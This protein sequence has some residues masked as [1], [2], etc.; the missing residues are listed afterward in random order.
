MS[1][2]YASRK[3]HLEKAT[4]GIQYLHRDPKKIE[5]HNYATTLIS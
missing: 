2:Q 4:G 5:H 1:E 3:Q